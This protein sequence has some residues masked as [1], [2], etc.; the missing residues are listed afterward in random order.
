MMI[1]LERVHTSSKLIWRDI[2]NATGAIRDIV[3]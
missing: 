1:E 3:P 2:Y